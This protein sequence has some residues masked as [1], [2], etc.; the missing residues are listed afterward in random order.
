MGNPNQ[1]SITEIM[2][3]EIV[4]PEFYSQDNEKAEMGVKRRRNIRL[5]K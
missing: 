5:V 1:A 4:K 2:S 3:E